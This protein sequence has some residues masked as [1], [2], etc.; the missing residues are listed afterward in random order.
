MRS[1]RNSASKGRASLGTPV[2]GN[3]GFNGAGTGGFDEDG[4][5][6]RI[7]AKEMNVFLLLLEGE[8]LI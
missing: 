3:M 1:L 6:R 4:Y 2:R 7:A 8:I 5:S